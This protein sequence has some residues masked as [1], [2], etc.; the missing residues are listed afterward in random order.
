ML[1]EA[2]SQTHSFLCFQSLQASLASLN[3]VDLATMTVTLP[4]PPSGLP[5]P[6][7]SFPPPTGPSPAPIPRPATTPLPS[8]ASKDPS[9]GVQR[10]GRPEKL[11]YALCPL[12]SGLSPALTKTGDHS[13][14]LPGVGGLSPWCC[15]RRKIEGAALAGRRWSLCLLCCVTSSG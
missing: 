1:G 12:S 4:L 13:I 8:P 7:A 2:S 14:S 6:D 5:P 10:G 9:P 3:K 15:A 11:R